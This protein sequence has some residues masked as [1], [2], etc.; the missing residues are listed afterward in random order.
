MIS[1]TCDAYNELVI[2]C[3]QVFP[4]NAIAVSYLETKVNLN[5]DNDKTRYPRSTGPQCCVIVA[6]GG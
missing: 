6:K 4:L 3:S 2:N 5:W 1:S